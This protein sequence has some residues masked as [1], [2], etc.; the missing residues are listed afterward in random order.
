MSQK[1]TFEFFFEDFGGKNKASDAFMIQI[2]THLDSSLY[3]PGKII[4]DE[5]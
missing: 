3:I 1:K 5:N 4:C 2:L